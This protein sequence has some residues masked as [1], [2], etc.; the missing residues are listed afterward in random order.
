MLS[1]LVPP[2]IVYNAKPSG[3]GKTKRKA[4]ER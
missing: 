1:P 2:K 3:E 4:Y